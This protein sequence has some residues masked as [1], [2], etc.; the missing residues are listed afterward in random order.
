MAV[1]DWPPAYLILSYS[2]PSCTQTEVEYQL[3][4]R[5][6]SGCRSPL[7]SIVTPLRSGHVDAVAVQ[8]NENKTLHDRAWLGREAKGQARREEARRGEWRREKG[9]RQEVKE[10]DERKTQTGRQV[11]GQSAKR[12]GCILLAGSLPRCARPR[13]RFLVRLT[14]LV[15]VASYLVPRCRPTVPTTTLHDY[16]IGVPASWS[17][18][19]SYVSMQVW[20][21]GLSPMTYSNDKQSRWI[22]QSTF[23]SGVASWVAQTPVPRCGEASAFASPRVQDGTAQ[24]RTA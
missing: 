13:L 21:C 24:H 5:Q 9:T 2:A 1:L 17:G 16:R 10:K 12:G 14:A 18:P 22:D 3:R 19:E 11:A 4:T 7:A 23:Y 8:Q 6:S 15:L 20:V